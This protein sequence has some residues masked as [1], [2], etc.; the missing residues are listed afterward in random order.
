LG[1]VKDIL[2]WGGGGIEKG[3]FQKKV[4]RRFLHQGNG[5]PGKT[6]TSEMGVAIGRKKGGAPRGG[7]SK[8]DRADTLERAVAQKKMDRLE[9]KRRFPAE[10]KGDFCWALFSLRKGGGGKSSRREMG[11]KLTAGGLR[12]E[13]CIRNV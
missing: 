12:M 8:A 4:R 11:P 7:P 2:M 10:E 9:K 6:L 3:G 5:S 1:F 13:I